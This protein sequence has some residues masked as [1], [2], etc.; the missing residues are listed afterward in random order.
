[1]QDS[2]VQRFIHKARTS[3]DQLAVVIVSEDGE[4]EVTYGRLFSTAQGHALRLKSQGI[5]AGDLVVLVLPHG[6]ELFSG[7]WGLF[8]LGAA[9][10]IHKYLLPAQDTAMYIKLAHDLLNDVGAEAV[11]TSPSFA[12]QFSVQ[13]PG[14]KYKIIHSGQ[15]NAGLEENLHFDFLDAIN[16]EDTALI[17]FSSGTTGPRKGVVLTWQTVT[18]YLEVDAITFD[19]RP[20][21]VFVNWLPLNH[22]MGLIGNFLLPFDMG[23]PI[24]LIS[25]FHWAKDP[26]ILFRM[27]SKYKGISTRMPNSAFN[28]SASVVS[29]ED[30]E[31]VDLSSWR[32]CLNGAEQ[33]YDQSLRVFEE[34]FSKYGL[35]H[36]ALRPAYGMAE[37]VL[38]ITHTPINQDYV[39]DW[40]DNEKFHAENKAVPAPPESENSRVFVSSGVAYRG[41]EIRI[42]DEQEKTLPD[43]RVGEIVVRSQTM[44][45]EYLNQ[46]EIT[47][48]TIKNGWLSTGDLGYLVEDQLFICG[49]KKDLIIVHGQ[50]IYPE[51]IEFTANSFPQVRAGRSVAFGI[52]DDRTGTERIVLVAELRKRLDQEKRNKLS[53]DIRSQLSGSLGI[54][55]QHIHFVEKGWVIKTSSG[56]VARS[57]NREKYL[58]SFNPL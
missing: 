4:E 26:A 35:K 25:P 17:Q 21:D 34:R 43:R 1:M 50:N 32:S 13:E 29:D 57:V 37:T 58:A 45:K 15:P 6:M 5:Q 10:S 18:D 42:I 8:L 51:D 41:V 55:V 24:V 38:G 31:G 33:I 39:V 23:I 48:E 16:P 49:R 7:I 56:K 2:F 11:L 27:I 14:A 9:P 40:V 30:L 52:P 36:S 22:D 20:G 46:P 19:T 53:R 3:P 47:R 12:D 44:M 28:F 54:L